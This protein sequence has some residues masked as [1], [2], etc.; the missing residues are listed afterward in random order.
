MKLSIEHNRN[1]SIQRQ[2]AWSE[3]FIKY[4]GSND[5]QDNIQLQRSYLITDQ[6][7]RSTI[8][9]EN[10][11]RLSHVFMD[12]TSNK[13]VLEKQYGSRYIAVNVSNNGIYG[14]AYTKKNQLLIWN[15]KNKKVNKFNGPSLISMQTNNNKQKNLY[16]ILNQ[17]HYMKRLKYLLLMMVKV[18]F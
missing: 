11:C 12:G 1:F 15:Q 8:G 13:S 14:V 17:M 5:A 6:G 9:T 18:L 16:L 7:E 2:K 3:V 4:D 10:N